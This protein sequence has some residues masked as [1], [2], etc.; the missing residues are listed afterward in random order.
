M[1]IFF[2][3]SLEK[4]TKS[5]S[6]MLSSHL[7]SLSVTFQD[8]TVCLALLHNQNN[9]DKGGGGIVEVRIITV[10]FKITYNCLNFL[11]NIVLLATVVW[12]FRKSFYALL[13]FMLRV[14]TSHFV[15]TSFNYGTVWTQKLKKGTKYQLHRDGP[16]TG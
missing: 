2:H 15:V 16:F 11:S 14:S 1:A 13:P 10:K 12:H 7:P 5:N 4:V 9:I 3:N 8:L 6:E